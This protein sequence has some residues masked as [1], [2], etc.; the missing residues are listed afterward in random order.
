[1]TCDQI[2][3][4]W[5][6]GANSDSI[7]FSRAGVQQVVVF[8]QNGKSSIEIPTD[9]THSYYAL[10]A[11]ECGRGDTSNVLTVQRDQVPSPVV[12]PRIDGEC[13]KD[14]LIFP[15]AAGALCAGTDERRIAA[16]R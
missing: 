5:V 16:T 10:G 2:L 1:M 9:G 6:V 12:D 14:A 7:A 15:L 3:F 11:N 4:T 13:G 8:G